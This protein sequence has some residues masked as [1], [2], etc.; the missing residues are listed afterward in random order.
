MAEIETVA[1]AA[2]AGMV[3]ALWRDVVRGAMVAAVPTY[4]DINGSYRAD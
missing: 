4:G 1:P 2:A 3:G